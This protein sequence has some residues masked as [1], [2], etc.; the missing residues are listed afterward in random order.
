MTERKISYEQALALER[1]QAA[2]RREARRRA[3]ETPT[4]M[5]DEER[6]AFMR[7]FST[8]LLQRRMKSGYATA[9]DRAAIRVVLAERRDSE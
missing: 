8:A 9:E 2:A 5:T 1:G 3:S 7:T 6:V 4:L